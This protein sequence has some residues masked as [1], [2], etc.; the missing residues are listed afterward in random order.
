MEKASFAGGVWMPSLTS[1]GTDM[2]VYFS[3]EKD[4]TFPLK[5]FDIE[6]EPKSILKVLQESGH[7][8]FAQVSRVFQ[9]EDGQYYYLAFKKDGVSWED[10][11]KSDD[12]KK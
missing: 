8:N 1:G 6:E 2:E 7:P 3:L 4:T 11:L 5:R 9:V 10:F 12:N